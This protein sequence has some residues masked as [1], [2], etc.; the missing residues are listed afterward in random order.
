MPENGL[1]IN[2][3]WTK[4]IENVSKIHKKQFKCGLNQFSSLFKDTGVKINFKILTLACQELTC[5]G[6]CAL[7]IALNTQKRTNAEYLT[8]FFNGFLFF[9]TTH[10]VNLSPRKK[11]LFCLVDS[12][13]AAHEC[14]PKIWNIV[15]VLEIPKSSLWNLLSFA[16]FWCISNFLVYLAKWL[17]ACPAIAKELICL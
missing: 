1:W 15:E 9:G 14:L 17:T 11:E 6:F 2:N 5:I 16:K 7:G 8:T 4:Y 10:Y 13:I 3:N 12:K